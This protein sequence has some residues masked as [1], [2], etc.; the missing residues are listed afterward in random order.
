MT[1]LHVS[2]CEYSNQFVC[3]FLSACVSLCYLVLCFPLS[4]AVYD[5]SVSVSRFS[6]SLSF[7]L[8]FAAYVNHF[9]VSV[10]LFSLALS[11]P[12]SLSLFFLSFFNVKQCE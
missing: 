2:P 11:F 5:F 9:T 7:P 10:S 3:L 8:S 12:I 4:V 1:T 6:L